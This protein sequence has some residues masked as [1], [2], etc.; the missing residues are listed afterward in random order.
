MQSGDN[1]GNTVVWDSAVLLPSGEVMFIGG[2]D[3]DDFNR[4]TLSWAPIYHPSVDSWSPSSM[5]SDRHSF[6]ATV[7]PSRA[8]LVA[9]GGI[10]AHFFTSTTDRAEIYRESAQPWTQGPALHQIRHGHSVTSLPNGSIMVAGG[11][12]NAVEIIERTQEGILTTR[13][14]NAMF[15]SRG[16]HT[17]TLL[18]TG[19]V[20]VAG[21]GSATAELFDPQTETWEE[22]PQMEIPRSHHTATLLPSG[23]VLLVGGSGSSNSTEV[24]D[25]QAESWHSSAPSL[26]RRAGHTATLLLSGSVIV[27]GGQ[28]LSSSEI[29][30]PVADSWHESTSI[31][32]SVAFHS[33]SLLA[34]GRVLIVGGEVRDDPGATSSC[35]IF[36]PATGNWSAVSALPKPRMW[37]S[38]QTLPSG[39][40]FVVGGFGGWELS[41]ANQV[42]ST[43]IQKGIPELGSP[44]SST[45]IFDPKTQAWRSGPSLA[46]PRHDHKSILS[47]A[48]EVVVVGG[49]EWFDEI[50]GLEVLGTDPPARVRAPRISSS[51]LE[52]SHHGTLTL[53]GSNLLG[54]SE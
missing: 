54:D 38:A 26:A 17:A 49:R 50:L 47:S 28:G 18:P 34:D 15:H 39:E 10:R 29:Y 9:G 36:D 37:H 21:G 46:Q 40:V 25:P 48:N 5:I 8:V 7:L 6:T 53:E 41:P 14:S 22:L 27:A 44:L 12:T 4:D 1:S 31:G 42:I 32:D 16:H 52:L 2:A 30:D 51:V 11:G 33:A 13:L 3:G 20:L 24:F 35:A 19:K 43:K 23:K 45:V